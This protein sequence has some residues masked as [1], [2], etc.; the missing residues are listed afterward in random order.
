MYLSCTET[1]YNNSICVEKTKNFA[2]IVV[3]NVSV[4]FLSDKQHI[5]TFF[6]VQSSPQRESHID[7]IISILL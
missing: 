4:F 6:I 2:Q 7:Y 1:P 5:T 3:I